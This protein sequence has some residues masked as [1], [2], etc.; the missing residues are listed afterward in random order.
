MAFKETGKTPEGGTVVEMGIPEGGDTKATKPDPG[1]LSPNF[2]AREFGIDD[3]KAVSPALIQALEELRVLAGN[4]PITVTSGVRSAE[5]NKKVGGASGSRHLHGDAADIKIGDLTV[6]EMFR[7]ASSVE[8]FNAGGIGVYPNDGVIHVDTRG[9]KARWGRIDV[10]TNGQKSSKFVPVT[11]ALGKSLDQLMDPDQNPHPEDRSDPRSYPIPPQQHSRDPFTSYAQDSERADFLDETE[12]KFGKDAAKQA[13]MFMGKSIKNPDVR[14]GLSPATDAITADPYSEATF[15]FFSDAVERTVLGRSSGVRSVAGALDFIG[16]T[17]ESLL[18]PSNFDP[19]NVLEGLAAGGAAGGGGIAVQ[20]AAKQGAKQLTDVSE[21]AFQ[22]AIDARRESV[23]LEAKRIQQDIND[24]THDW[25]VQLSA[26]DKEGASKIRKEINALSVQK[27]KANMRLDPDSFQH[28][29]TDIE[30]E[31]ADLTVAKN[32]VTDPAEKQA[33]IKQIAGAEAR[34]H[35]LQKQIDKARAEMKP[36]TADSVTEALD[37]SR[38]LIESARIADEWRK[39]LA[40]GSVIGKDKLDAKITDLE[41]NIADLVTQ[42]QGDPSIL[43]D[44]K[45][46]ED[47]LAKTKKIAATVEGREVNIASIMGRDLDALPDAIAKT[48]EDIV[49]SQSSKKLDTLAEKMMA[50]KPDEIIDIEHQFMDQFRIMSTLVGKIRRS[51]VQ[52]GQLL[53]AAR[54]KS[55]RADTITETMERMPK[56]SNPMTIAMQWKSLRTSRQREAYISALA[57]SKGAFWGTLE[58]IY[59]NA[60][61]SSPAT[62]VWN[63]ASMATL[64]GARILERQLA[65]GFRD[66]DVA[67]GEAGVLASSLVQSYYKLFVAGDEMTKNMA[68]KEFDRAKAIFQPDTIDEQTAAKLAL[69]TSRGSIFRASGKYGK[70]VDV[71]GYIVNSPRFLVASTDSLFRFAIKDAMIQSFAYRQAYQEAQD[72]LRRGAEMSR[73]EIQAFINARRSEISQDPNASI[74]YKGNRVK[75]SD[76]AEEEASVIAMMDDLRSPLGKKTDEMMRNSTLGRLAVPFFRVM[77]ITARETIERAGPAAMLMPSVRRDIE[78]GGARAAEA[79]AKMGTGAMLAAGGA[80]MWASGLITDGGP[81]DPELNAT[82]QNGNSPYVVKIDGKEI[83]L[84]R[85]GVVG[86]VLAYTADVA[87]IMEAIPSVYEASANDPES[88]GSDLV[89]QAASTLLALHTALIGSDILFNDAQRI[90]RAIAAGDGPALEQIVQQRAGSAVPFS[91]LSKD[92]REF[93]D[94]DRKSADGFLASMQRSLP[95]GH[96]EG[97]STMRNGWGDKTA[98]FENLSIAEVFV[99]LTADN[100]PRAEIKNAVA[101]ELVKSQVAIPGPGRMFKREGV[102]T[103]LNMTEWN[104]LKEAF[105]KVVIEGNHMDEALYRLQRTPAWKN[106][107]G[108]PR[109]S[110]DLLADAIVEPYRK[111]AR[112]WLYSG[113]PAPDIGLPEPSPY[114]ASLQQR[115]IQNVHYRTDTLT[116]MG[117]EPEQSSSTGGFSVGFTR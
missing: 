114:A 101:N 44:I 92:I 37:S 96:A 20:R 39:D 38:S 54:D 69:P 15:S 26:G 30:S 16:G 103:R 91:A 79:K 87:R 105:G 19:I 81:L 85:L 18:D 102:T 107:T 84:N 2:H 117:V 112:E 72:Q 68:R 5:H 21:K 28:E 93:I 74:I 32:K 40:V 89:S 57:G 23:S 106:G 10:I 24:L 70:A 76:I 86:N 17:I 33:L 80:A 66:S 113:E 35:R 61:I 63:V 59:L 53:R 1:Q 8:A 50:A 75:L 62:A 100:A 6:E 67:P 48:A 94:K 36:V 46:L 109:G 41:D 42:A 7:L 29:V 95:F 99:G 56:G 77:A 115:V 22:K 51:E 14:K 98:D 31:I 65:A 55:M 3:P 110:K 27:R 49:L 97:M 58:D 64:T 12:A 78:A 25:S 108:G 4:Q 90:L 73:K 47:I 111:A 83:P 43:K 34:K 13:A 45:G 88:S 71:L 52:A 11:E 9:Q 60:L 104:A 116:Q 82:W